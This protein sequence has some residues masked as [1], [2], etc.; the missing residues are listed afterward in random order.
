[1]LRLAGLGALFGI[2]SVPTYLVAWA[3]PHT[4]ADALFYTLFCIGLGLAAV[5]QPVRAA[6][7]RAFPE[8]ARV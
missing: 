4:T 7:R 5:M 1:M 3:T 8:R 6:V 2:T